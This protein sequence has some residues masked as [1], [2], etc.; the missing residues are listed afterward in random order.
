MIPPGHGRNAVLGP[1][2]H[3]TRTPCRRAEDELL[4]R[5]TE[6]PRRFVSFGSWE[7]VGAI[8]RLARAPGY[9]ERIDRL[10]RVVDGFGPRTLEVV[11]RR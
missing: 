2:V 6:D 5:D 4:P 8:G 7:S 3:A 10:R 11:A 1:V 9:R